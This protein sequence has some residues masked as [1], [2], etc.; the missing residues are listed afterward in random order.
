MASPVLAWR[1]A[2]PGK[3]GDRRAFSFEQITRLPDAADGKGRGG[4]RYRRMK[5][6]RT[7]ARAGFAVFDVKISSTYAPTKLVLP[8]QP[9]AFLVDDCNR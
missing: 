3:P 4:A 8:I 7:F 9:A 2:E 6:S 1:G 5:K